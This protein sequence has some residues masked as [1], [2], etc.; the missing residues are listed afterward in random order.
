MES[1]EQTVISILNSH[2]VAYYYPAESEK[3]E[4]SA[5]EYMQFFNLKTEYYN[6]YY[7]I[8]N[9]DTY[10][11]YNN[12]SMVTLFNH[13]DN[14]MWFTGDIEFQA[15]ENIYKAI[16]KCDLL[17]IEHHAEN[18]RSSPK[19]LSQLN[20]KFSVVCPRLLRLEHYNSPTLFD[21]KS[22][23]SKLYSTYYNSI[24]H[25]VSTYNNLYPENATEYELVNTNLLNTPRS[26]YSRRCGL[27]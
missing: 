23:N 15:E 9:E 24:I 13:L 3:I 27:K 2:S 22:K 20:P 21:T 8:L 26:S 19:Y 6:Q 25:F 7:N 5:N 11:N 10:T 16:N 1:I 4:L 17:K 12:F 18:R 14:F